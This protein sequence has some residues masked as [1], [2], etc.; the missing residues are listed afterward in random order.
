M[1]NNKI[2]IVI[3]IL[4]LIILS[5]CSKND[6]N[7]DIKQNCDVDI[8]NL[9]NKEISI[10]TKN[11]NVEKIDIEYPVVE[12]NI[13]DKILEKINNT[14][15]A[16]IYL[17]SINNFTAGNDVSIFLNYEINYISEDMLSISFYGSIHYPNTAHPNQ[18]VSSVNIDLN[19]GELIPLSSIVKIDDLLN[20]V[21]KE[22]AEDIKYSNFDGMKYHQYMYARKH[23]SK[24]LLRSY[25]SGKFDVDEMFLYRVNNA[26]YLKN[27]SLVLSLPLIYAM[28][29]WVKMEIPFEEVNILKDG[30]NNYKELREIE[31]LNSEYAAI[32]NMTNSS[33]EDI[34]KTIDSYIAKLENIIKKEVYLKMSDDTLNEL[35]DGVKFNTKYSFRDGKEYRYRMFHMDFFPYILGTLNSKFIIFQWEDETGLHSKVLYNYDALKPNDFIVCDDKNDVNILLSGYRHTCF[36]RSIF[37]AAYHI[38]NGEMISK[39]IDENKFEKEEFDVYQNEVYLNMDSLAHISE[40]HY[41]KEFIVYKLGDGKPKTYYK[42]RFENDELAYDKYDVAELIPKYL[43]KLDVDNKENFEPIF[44]HCYPV[45]LTTGQ[46]VFHLVYKLK[47]KHISVV[48]ALADKDGNFISE[49]KEFNN[50]SI[51]DTEFVEFNRDGLLDYIVIISAPNGE[52]PNHAFALIGR[53]DASFD[54]SFLLDK[55]N[56]EK[57]KSIGIEIE[58]V[59]KVY[60][61]YYNT[62]YSFD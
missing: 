29:G 26:Y 7:N 56:K 5:S 60:D 13:D 59:K 23:Y 20:A 41:A 47:G 15:I 32:K 58:D 16:T 18:I 4:L 55:L 11:I 33:F 50:V 2:K 36:P 21:N 46:D 51:K 14:I 24:E 8:G 57:G 54:E 52:F 34:R 42:F 27:N 44:E 38:K 22:L 30:V 45:H 37:L 40:K 39:N 17:D 61:D 9:K 25:F 35:F 12:G 1:K 28:G 10:I 53:Y 43:E 31:D 6:C 62:L 48:C 49:L 19:T 3:F